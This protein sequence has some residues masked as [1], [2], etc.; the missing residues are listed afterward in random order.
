MTLGFSNT[1]LRVLYTCS[2]TSWLYH[3]GT[4]TLPWN[5]MCDYWIS[6]PFSSSV[7][8][9]LIRKN[10]FHM[11]P[12]M[13]L[14]AEIPWW[15]KRF[16]KSQRWIVTLVYSVASAWHSWSCYNDPTFPSG[17]EMS[18][19]S[20]GLSFLPLHP[21]LNEFQTHHDIVLSF[22]WSLLCLF[23]WKGIPVQPIS[24]H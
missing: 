23:L 15:T 17:D 5:H 9:P 24:P 3:H 13:W 8:S 6:R 16:Y 7:L 22:C 11:V 4:N 1:L 18:V 2:V 10:K 12:P 21:H 19:L 14:R 20:R